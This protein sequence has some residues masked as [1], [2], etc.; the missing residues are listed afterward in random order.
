MARRPRAFHEGIYHLGSHG[1]DVRNLFLTDEDRIDFLGRLAATCRRFD[2]PLLSYVLMGNHYHVLVSTEDARISDALQRLHTGYSRSHNRRHDRNAHLFLA[3]PFA[4]EVDGSDDLLGTLRY[5]A[6]NPVE[7]GFVR[8][9]LDWQWSSAR[10]H[11]GVGPPHVP[12]DET[13]T[14]GAF[15]DPVEWRPRY[16]ALIEPDAPDRLK[17][18]WFPS[19]LPAWDVETERVGIA[20]NG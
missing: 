6:L 16:A 20:A 14:N 18:D 3:H 1:S 10:A 5:L 12:L 17:L 7:A 2:L 4:R 9:P 19:I 8:H 15:D 11:A 13:Y